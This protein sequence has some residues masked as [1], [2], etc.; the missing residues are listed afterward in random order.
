MSVHS[1]T[2]DQ[3]PPS[4]EMTWVEFQLVPRLVITALRYRP[5]GMRRDQRKQFIEELQDSI[6]LVTS[7]IHAPRGSLSRDI[8]SEAKSTLNDSLVRTPL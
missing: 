2:S 8:T 3:A 1:I 6:S 5:P 7:M 4:T